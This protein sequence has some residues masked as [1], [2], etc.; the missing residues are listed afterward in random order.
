MLARDGD[1]MKRH[2]E[3]FIRKDGLTIDNSVQKIMKPTQIHKGVK[4][5]E[6]TH[7]LS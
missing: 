1:E 3:E 2:F 6:S 5:V 4:L 7:L